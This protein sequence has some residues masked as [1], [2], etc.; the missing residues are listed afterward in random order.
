VKSG[1]DLT[2]LRD[3]EHVKE[4]LL[5]IRR[6]S[7]SAM[8]EKGAM[9]ELRG[10]EWTGSLPAEAPALMDERLRTIETYM[11][12]ISSDILDRGSCSLTDFAEEQCSNSPCIPKLDAALSKANVTG[13]ECGEDFDE[14]Q[15]PLV[16]QDLF[17]PSGNERTYDSDGD[18]ALSSTRNYLNK[19]QS[20][21]SNG[22]PVRSG[23][24]SSSKGRSAAHVLATLDECFDGVGR[25]WSDNS[26][27]KKADNDEEASASPSSSMSEFDRYYFEFFA[28][29]VRDRK[30]T[31]S[32]EASASDEDQP[33]TKDIN[34]SR[35]DE[36][37]PSVLTK[38][39]TRH[40][41]QDERTSEADVSSS[42]FESRADSACIV[43]ICNVCGGRDDHLCSLQLPSMPTTAEAELE[44]RVEATPETGK[45]LIGRELFDMIE[46]SSPGLGLRSRRQGSVPRPIAETSKEPRSPSLHE[47]Q[48]HCVDATDPFSDDRYIRAAMEW[49]TE[50][51]FEVLCDFIEDCSPDPALGHKSL[52][53]NQKRLTQVSSGQRRALR[54]ISANQMDT[55]ENRRA[56]FCSDTDVEQDLD[57]TDF[58][59]GPRTWNTFQPWN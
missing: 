27:G 11:Q 37:E 40:A 35:A 22:S 13:Q 19:M 5:M 29:H 32:T 48:Q 56:S 23:P 10:A 50:N 39:P 42:S 43:P 51:P 45:R 36:A 44:E 33:M 8:A 54:T 34:V 7:A 31:D 55:Q 38:K 26:S 6:D 14:Y 12:K 15:S 25:T 41:W 59:M 9:I 16:T 47:S 28:N 52:Q 20:I 57:G 24:S 4:I 17:Y 46:R 3:L 49:E 30:L 53:K 18:S 21:A 58:T 1:D 2:P